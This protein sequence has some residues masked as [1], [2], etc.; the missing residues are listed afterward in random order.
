M[1]DMG[2]WQAFMAAVTEGLNCDAPGCLTNPI[3]ERNGRPLC[4]WHR[5]VFDHGTSGLPCDRCGSREW[6]AT[7]DAAS[8]AICATCRFVTYDEGVIE[9]SW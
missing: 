7:P 6:V 2:D 9:H 1:S 4:A 3:A 5:D 8:V